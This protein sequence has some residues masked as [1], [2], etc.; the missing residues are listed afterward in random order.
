MHSH[1]SKSLQYT[2]FPMVKFKTCSLNYLLPMGETE[3]KRVELKSRLQTA[4]KVG[5]GR[6][7]H[8]ETSWDRSSADAD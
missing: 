4:S 6:S 1:T 3:K 2:H 5:F 7:L 8:S